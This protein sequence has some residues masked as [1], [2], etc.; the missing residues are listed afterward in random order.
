MKKSPILLFIF[1]A[2]APT[3]ASEHGCKVL[4]CLANPASNGGPK[5]IAECVPSI[6]QLYR[7][8]RKGRP[9]PTCDLADGNDGSSYAR[10][11]F[12]PYDPCVA[13]LQAALPG[14]VVVQ[15]QLQVA[16]GNSR[17]QAVRRAYTLK[18]QPQVSEQLDRDGERLGLRAC[19][20]KPIGS[21]STGGYDDSSTVSVFDQVV[22]QSPQSSQA[23]DVFIDNGWRH[24]VRW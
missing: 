2:A 9:F 14:T 16:S 18:G 15:G 12:D 24:R 13:P 3:Q 7:D 10:V 19:V 22:W 21:Y 8:L 1:C 4:L 17:T 5:G 20:G 23:I 11:V 6:N